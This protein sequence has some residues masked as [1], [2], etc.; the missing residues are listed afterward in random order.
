VRFRN[1]YVREIPA[2]EGKE[3]LATIPAAVPK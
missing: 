1:I 3:L 2:P